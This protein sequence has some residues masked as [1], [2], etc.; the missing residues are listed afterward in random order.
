MHPVFPRRIDDLIVDQLYFGLFFLYSSLRVTAPEHRR[1]VA[2]ERG[3]QL[4]PHHDPIHD[5]SWYLDGPLRRRLYDEYAVEGYPI[6]Q[7]AGDAVFI[8]A[9]A[10]H[11]V[12][13]PRATTGA[14]QAAGLGT[15]CAAARGLASFVSRLMSSTEL[16]TVGGRHG[17]GLRLPEKY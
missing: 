4:E 11:Q 5:Q 13:G 9:G 15:A 17:Y 1:Q 14:G 7:C 6:V 8:P 10:P 3:D 16:W 12:R 2:I